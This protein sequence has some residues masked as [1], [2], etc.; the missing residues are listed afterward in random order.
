MHPNGISYPL[1]LVSVDEGEHGR[2]AEEQVKRHRAALRRR[3]VL[4]V[5]QVYERRDHPAL[6]QIVQTD[7][8]PYQVA[9]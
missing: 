3:L 9:E 5:R 8:K 2:V 7:A 4:R 6:N 1:Y